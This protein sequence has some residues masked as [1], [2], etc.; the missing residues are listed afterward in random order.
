MYLTSDAGQAAT[1]D[2][3]VFVAAQLDRLGE[4]VPNELPRLA[5]E[6]P[7]RVVRHLN[8]EEPLE[9]AVTR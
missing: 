3:Y 9:S 1:G 8:A 6:H 2:P 5:Q 4:Q 7:D